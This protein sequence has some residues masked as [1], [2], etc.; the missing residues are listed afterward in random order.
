[1]TPESVRSEGGLEAWREKHLLSAKVWGGLVWPQILQQN[2]SQETLKLLP[3]QLGAWQL[4]AYPERAWLDHGAVVV[5]L[6]GGGDGVDMGGQDLP[7]KLA[8]LSFPAG[9]H[10]GDSEFHSSQ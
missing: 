6:V 4:S 8:H 1:M 9:Y 10:T 3:K 5:L 2:Q 7:Q